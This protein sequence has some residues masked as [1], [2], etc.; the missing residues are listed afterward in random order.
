[1]T[2]PKIKL[3]F[4][5]AQ[6]IGMERCPDCGWH[7]ETQGH[8]P[9]CPTHPSDAPDPPTVRTPTKKPARRKQERK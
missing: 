3:L 4:T 7:P 6:L 8:L 5:R 1:M 9:E 2:D